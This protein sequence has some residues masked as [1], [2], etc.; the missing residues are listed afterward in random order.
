[1]KWLEAGISTSKAAVTTFPD[2]CC[3]LTA[4]GS[5]VIALRLFFRFIEQGERLAQHLE[6]LL[7]QQLQLG[8]PAEPCGNGAREEQQPTDDG[9]DQRKSQEN[10]RQRAGHAAAL[11]EAHDREQDGRD[12]PRQQ[13]RHQYGLAQLGA[14]QKGDDEEADDRELGRARPRV[15]GHGLGKALA[16]LIEPRRPCRGRTGTTIRRPSFG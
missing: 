8:D 16:A 3:T 15:E 1:M 12:H 14:P 5:L 9:A 11:Q 4:P 13:H 2:G 6:L 7:Q 10:G